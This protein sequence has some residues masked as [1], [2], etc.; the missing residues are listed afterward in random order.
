MGYDDGSS[1]TLANDTLYGPIANKN[2]IFNFAIDTSKEESQNRDRIMT[3]QSQGCV[4]CEGDTT[5]GGKL[6][7]P[8]PLFG[9]RSN[10]L[11][12]IEKMIASQGRF[13]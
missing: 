10:E 6:M 12:S 3:C 7:K 2:S 4:K 8:V 13:L 1:A 9:G 5:M 11:A